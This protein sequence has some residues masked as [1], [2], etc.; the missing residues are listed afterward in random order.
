MKGRKTQT[1]QKTDSPH[2]SAENVAMDVQNEQVAIVD[3]DNRVIGAATR[4]RMRR[5]NLIHRA[6]YILVFNGSGEI[7]VHQRTFTKDVYPGYWDVA[8]G[9]VVMAGETYD[10]SAHRE[11]AEELGIAGR[12]LK[13]LF[14]FFWTDDRCR[15]WGRVYRCIYSGPMRLQPEEV[16][17]GRFVPV[18]SVLS[19]LSAEKI[20]PDG[21]RVLE[22]YRRQHHER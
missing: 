1:P 15:V 17:R 10:A 12:P 3:G 20:T 7:F 9:G 21:L 22:T 13:R 18:S 16:I 19:E 5:E 6:T 14:D 2:G 11:L 8:A 4:G